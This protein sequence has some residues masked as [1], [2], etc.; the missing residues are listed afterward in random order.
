M[1]SSFHLMRDYTTVMPASIL[2]RPVR[3]FPLLVLLLLCKMSPP[4]TW[5]G[6]WQDQVQGEGKG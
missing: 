5:L 4:G 6:F 3:T 1:S 2:C